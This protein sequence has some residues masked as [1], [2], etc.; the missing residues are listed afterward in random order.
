MFRRVVQLWREWQQHRR[1]ARR[2]SPRVVRELA[3]ELAHLSR[4][5]EYAMLSGQDPVPLRRLREE[6]EALAR[7]A[8]KPEFLRLPT[9]RRAAICEQLRRSQQYLIA[10][11]QNGAPP[12]DRVQ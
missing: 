8:D 7:M 3:V 9:E 10:T 4:L 6:M 1:M 12:T 11:M 5:A 2:S